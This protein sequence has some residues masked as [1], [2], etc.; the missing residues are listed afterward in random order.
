M[1]ELKFMETNE[2]NKM[3]EAEVFP[4]KKPD[5]AQEEKAGEI[6]GEADNSTKE[7][8]AKKAKSELRSR[9]ILTFVLGLLI[10]IAIKTEAL[11]RITIGYND[12]L[13][14]IKSQDYNINAIQVALEKQAQEAAQIQQQQDGVDDSE[15]AV[16]STATDNSGDI[17][18]SSVAPTVD[19]GQ[20][21]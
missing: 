18:G 16:D 11:K 13:M 19:G 12:Y 3:Q 4:E 15:N 20:N 8:I 1:T 10:G 17:D 14:K 6:F 9:L 2:E 21:N 5:E 7:N